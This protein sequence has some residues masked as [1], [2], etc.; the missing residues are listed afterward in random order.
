MVFKQEKRY[1]RLLVSTLNWWVN[2]M[3]TS[4]RFLHICWNPRGH[5]KPVKHKA[6]NYIRQENISKYTNLY[7]MWWVPQDNVIRVN[8]KNQ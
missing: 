2:Y 8:D 3:L 7:R 6:I 1:T 5:L 4:A